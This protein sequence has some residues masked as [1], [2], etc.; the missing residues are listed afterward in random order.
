[1]FR[2]DRTMGVVEH[3]RAILCPSRS[4]WETSW[5]CG[6]LS[7]WQ[8]PN[9]LTWWLPLSIVDSKL[10]FKLNSKRWF[11][12]LC[13]CNIQRLTV[14]LLL[15]GERERE[16]NLPITPNHNGLFLFSSLCIYNTNAFS[17]I[18]L[19]VLRTSSLWGLYWGG[20]VSYVW[21]SQ[22]LVNLI[23]WKDKFK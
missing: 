19:C 23:D 4:C 2:P 14:C 16:R 21:M 11:C 5:S 3:P 1:M 18:R 8:I 10:N 17:L 13:L 6:C 9:W 12:P 7:F 20:R 15:L 22:W